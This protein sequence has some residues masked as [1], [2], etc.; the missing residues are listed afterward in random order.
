[1]TI[2]PENVSYLAEAVFN[3]IDE[4]YTSIMLNCVFENV[5]ENKHATILYN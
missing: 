4:K 2:A 3:L 5:W 1:M